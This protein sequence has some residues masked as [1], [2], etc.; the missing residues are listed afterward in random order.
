MTTGSLTGVL[1]VAR[2]HR[3]WRNTG[4]P[5]PVRGPGPHA[6]GR[7]CGGWDVAGFRPAARSTVPAP[8]VADHATAASVGD[9]Q[10]CARNRSAGA[11]PPVFAVLRRASRLMRITSHTT[12][13]FRRLSEVIAQSRRAT[14]LAKVGAPD[15][16]AARCSLRPDGRL[17]AYVAVGAVACSGTMRGIASD[18]AVS[19]VRQTGERAAAPC[20]NRP[21]AHFRRPRRGGPS[22]A[23]ARRD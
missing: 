1:G 14:K 18:E 7:Q 16:G 20:A 5:S 19:E 10:S 11:R 17:V 4:R 23:R 8:A 13:A 15:M 3:A 12:F 9:V 22:H 21:E 2:R 6:C